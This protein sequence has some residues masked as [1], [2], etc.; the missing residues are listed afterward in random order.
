ADLTWFSSEFD[1]LIA[2]SFATFRPENIA[3]AQSEGVELTLAYEPRPGFHLSASHTW[4]DTEDRST[5]LPLARRPEHRSTLSLYFR[6]HERL[7]G[8]AT[9]VAASDRRDS[10]GTAMDDYERVDLTLHYRVSERFEPYL[11]VENL[12]DQEYEEINGYTTPGAHAVVGV[13][14]RF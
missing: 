3:R 11:R 4:N 2:Y 13:N 9:F 10:D 1:D 8:N 12:F 5:G 6:P 14:L 7:T